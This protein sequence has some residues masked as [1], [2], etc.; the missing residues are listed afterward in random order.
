MAM[1]CSLLGHDYGDPQVTHERDQRGSEVV[2]TVTEFERCQRCGKKHVISENTE[3]TSVGADAGGSDAGVVEQGPP[4]S[5]EA[6]TGPTGPTTADDRPAG[7]TEGADVEEPA[8]GDPVASDEGHG[9]RDAEPGV[10]SAESPGTA[11]A[12]EGGS[13]ATDDGEILDAEPETPRERG[14]GEWPE[15]DDVR[16]PRDTD[17]GPS[18]WV[19]TDRDEAGTETLEYDEAASPEEAS[20]RAGTE[21]RDPESADPDAADGGDQPADRPGVRST[22]DARDRVDPAADV[23]PAET[24]ANGTSSR[25]PESPPTETASGIASDQSAPAPGEGKQRAPSRS[26]FYCPQCDFVAP[27]D[28]GSLRTGDIC[29]NCRRGYLGERDR[30]P[31]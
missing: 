13:A 15:A 16:P 14:H 18:E 2:V 6:D 21:R 22:G 19:G 31:G 28:R 30:S 8:G 29:P 17:E 20:E 9:V 4:E 24:S 3:V 11:G 1:R 23:E 12:T 5:A 26:E 25:N 10:E 7:T 27:G